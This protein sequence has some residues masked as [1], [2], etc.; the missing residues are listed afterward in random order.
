MKII[1][2]GTMKGGTGKTTLAFNLAGMLA[3]HHKVLLWDIDPQCNLSQS[4]GMD[5]NTRDAYT[6]KDVFDNPDTPPEK[7]AVC[8]DDS[9]EG[10]LWI[11]P[12]SIDLTLTEAMLPSRAGR[13]LILHHYIEDNI[14][15][16]HQFDYI[17]LDT[18]P[19]MCNVN[20]NG[21]VAADSIVLVSDVSLHSIRGAE[22]FQYLWED[23]RKSLRLPETIKALVLNNYDVRT[24]LAGQL[25]SYCE[26]QDNL[27]DL[28]VRTVIPARV[29]MKNTAIESK[30]INQLQPES[31]LTGIFRSLVEEL[32]E[33]EVF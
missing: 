27:K 8:V 32:K 10:N 13:E 23:I 26:G 30:P 20:Q 28:I 3:E 6:A 5:I 1:A 14:D 24:K 11:M 21:F 2:F 7:I 9:L 33:K 25:M 17:L 18:N 19:S 15:F 31:D 12:G 22:L 16:F 29:A 4:V